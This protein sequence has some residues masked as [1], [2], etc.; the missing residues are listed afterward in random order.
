MAFAGGALTL[1]QQLCCSNAEE[2]VDLISGLSPRGIHA[3]IA[4][5]P[6]VKL[7]TGYDI[8]LADMQ[9]LT[10]ADEWR[11]QVIAGDPWIPGADNAGHL[12]L[13][14]FDN[15]FEAAALFEGH[16]LKHPFEKIE[17]SCRS[18]AE[19]VVSFLKLGQPLPAVWHH[20]RW[21]NPA[22]ATVTERLLSSNVMDILQPGQE[23]PLSAIVTLLAIS[24]QQTWNGSGQDHE[25]TVRNPHYPG[26]QAVASDIIVLP[27][28]FSITGV[29][30]APRCDVLASEYPGNMLRVYDILT[31][32]LVVVHPIILANN[33]VVTL[34]MTQRMIVLVTPEQLTDVPNSKQILDNA[35]QYWK[36]ALQGLRRAEYPRLTQ[37]E[38]SA[39]DGQEIILKVY[40]EVSNTVLLNAPMSVRSLACYYRTLDCARRHGHEWPPAVR[41]MLVCSAR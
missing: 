7:V 12:V 2:F 11:V 17:F 32:R 8:A 1:Q 33:W 25:S 39:R 13:M 38:R 14:F 31:A 36:T 15:H 16:Q 24:T 30:M 20:A 9:D 40:T 4:L 18:V 26:M 37:A 28:L 41:P 10:K 6:L 23:L 19:H 22:M 29:G 3:P 5:L 27:P 35:V 21:N 34:L